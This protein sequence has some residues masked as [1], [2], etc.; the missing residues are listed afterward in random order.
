MLSGRFKGT[1]EL[2]ASFRTAQ[3]EKLF[4]AVDRNVVV[5]FR[6]CAGFILE[7]VVQI[8]V[9][10]CAG[11]GTA[12]AGFDQPRGRVLN[13]QFNDIGIGRFNL[14][15]VGLEDQLDAVLGGRG[16]VA[17]LRVRGFKLA[18][19]DG[20]LVGQIVAVRVMED[21]G[22][23]QL[24]G[25]AFIGA[26][27]DAHRHALRQRRRGVGLFHREL[28]D[29]VIGRRG[30][31]VAVDMDGINGGF[32]RGDGER[33]VKGLLRAARSAFTDADQIVSGDVDAVQRRRID[34]VRLAQGDRRLRVDGDCRVGDF[35]TINAAIHAVSAV[36]R[37][38]LRVAH[39]RGGIGT[40][41][42]I[43]IVKEAQFTLIL[44][45]H[46]LIVKV[47]VHRVGK[48][49]GDKHAEFAR[50]VGL[51]GGEVVRRFFDRD[52]EL[53]VF[54]VGVGRADGHGVGAVRLQIVG[55]DAD[56]RIV[57]RKITAVDAV[58]V[59]QSVA[60]RVAENTC[61]IRLPISDVDARTELT[62]TLG[63]I[64]HDG[65]VVIDIRTGRCDRPRIHAGRF[66]VLK[67][68]RGAGLEEQRMRAGLGRGISIFVA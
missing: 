19:V 56:G 13:V 1:A 40:G 53:R 31:F 30:G 21:R 49:D 64:L 20:Y 48:P 23:V 37:F 7:D 60:V 41:R 16:G 5:E 45:V 39:G 8:H 32:L 51:L 3:E 67:G 43:T 68:F 17:V 42:L 44:G 11:C 25:N 24:P 63:R 38:S 54:A 47:G 9:G 26:G 66:A 6:E 46:V 58:G 28:H 52:G 55:V 4:S 36:G 29:I 18:V 12:A 50:R 61:Q 2:G 10:V 65:R 15:V 35:Y 33:A 14:T 59:G 27:L 57:F 22:E 34:G 62:G